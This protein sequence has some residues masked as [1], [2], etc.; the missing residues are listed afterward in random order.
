MPVSNP[1][2]DTFA[3]Y[4]HWPFCEAICPY[5]DFNVARARGVDEAEWVSALKSELQ[6]MA[7]MTQ[8]RMV[9]SVF[10]GGGTPSLMS[11]Q[12]VSQLIDEV[13][14]LWTLGARAEMTLEANPTDGEV[15]KFHGFAQSGINRLSLGVQSLRD[16]DLKLLGR[17]HDARQ[18]LGAYEAARQA[19]NNVSCDLIYAR[20]GQ[21]LGAWQ[22]ELQDMLDLEP[23]HL[24]LYQLTI[25]PGTAFERKYARG[26]LIMPDEAVMADL[27][28]LSQSLCEAHGL[29]A[30]EVSNHG[31]PD[32]QS[33]HN[34]SYWCYQDYI[35]VGPGA[36][37]RITIDGEKFSIQTVKKPKEWLAQTSQD[38]HG[39]GTMEALACDAQGMEMMLMG[40]RLCEGVDM[41][42]YEQIAGRKLNSTKVSAL[43]MDGLIETKASIIRPTSK[44]RMMLD[45]VLMRLLS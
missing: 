13:A 15:E 4:V 16:A 17:W 18:A 8:G 42:S 44:G 14:R 25:E 21:T 37:G 12:S 11:P 9:T 6:H 38:G 1:D 24:S 32:T 40:L 41:R 39:F 27:Y 22:D 7:S 10:F 33:A 26:D 45:H 2:P 19:F 23:D 29:P 28:A 36:H 34:L 5:C 20:P 3:V 43:Q 31:R 30:Y 35:G